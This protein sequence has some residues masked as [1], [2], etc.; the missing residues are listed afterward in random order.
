MKNN[1]ISNNQKINAND[2]IYE[3]IVT[4]GNATVNTE[5]D[6]LEVYDVNVVAEVDNLSEPPVLN[7]I[8]Y[9]TIRAI[10]SSTKPEI[11]NTPFPVIDNSDGSFNVFDHNVGYTDIYYGIYFYEAN[12]SLTTLNTL[13][14]GETN[15]KV[16]SDFGSV[17]SVVIS[18]DNEQPGELSIRISFDWFIRPQ[19]DFDTYSYSVWSVEDYNYTN[20]VALASGA[21]DMDSGSAHIDFTDLEPIIESNT[22]NLIYFIKL[23]NNSNPENTVSSEFNFSTNIGIKLAQA[24]TISFEF[25]VGGKTDTKKIKR[26]AGKTYD[27]IS[28]S[29]ITAVSYYGEGVEAPM[30]LSI[31]DESGKEWNA[32]YMAGNTPY[33]IKRITTYD[34]G[35]G[36]RKI[37]DYNKHIIEEPYT[38]SL[39]DV[40]SD[41]KISLSVKQN[42][43]EK[44]QQSFTVS[45]KPVA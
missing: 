37:S 32:P 23:T 10:D 17:S 20:G 12:C 44:Y 5:P 33:K 2:I 45:V 8:A 16:H 1:H 3:A 43:V 21:L 42:G 13:Y 34:W 41:Y 19:N 36:E 24:V 7:C 9:S 30:F 11:I 22:G 28:L 18:Y 4:P 39:S 26:A 6:W 15:P 31:K 38:F 27:D 25:E 35:D 29:L 14:D 40:S